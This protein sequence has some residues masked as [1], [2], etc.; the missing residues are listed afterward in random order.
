DTLSSRA[1]HAGVLLD[2]LEVKSIAT[3]DLGSFVVRKLDGL[4]DATISARLRKIWGTLQQSSAEKADRIARFKKQLTPEVLAKADL[5][6]GRELFS[7]TC[8]Q[9][10]TLFDVGGKVGPELTGANRKD[11]DYLLSN[12]VDPNAVVGKDYLATMVWM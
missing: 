3:R 1:R 4:K 9:C 11:L 8:Q 6:R 2:A 7:R 10:H 12:V 5:A